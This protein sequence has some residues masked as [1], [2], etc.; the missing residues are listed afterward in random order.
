[1]SNRGEQEPA[2]GRNHPD[3]L[4][5]SVHIDEETGETYTS[6][7]PVAV[8][9]VNKEFFGVG[10]VIGEIDDNPV[11]EVLDR[12]DGQPY[13]VMGY[14]TWWTCPVPDEIVDNMASGELTID[15]VAAYR[16]AQDDHWATTEMG[17]ASFLDDSGI[18]PES[19]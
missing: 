16:Q 14:E 17:D 9:G 1:M 7:F 13:C 12:D 4:G 10:Q 6:P 18:D 19:M 15:S 8:F 3:F 2:M 11:I 5:L